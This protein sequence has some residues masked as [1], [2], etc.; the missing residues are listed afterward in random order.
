MQSLTNIDI[1][2][3]RGR[4][5]FYAWAENQC[6][7]ITDEHMH[8]VGD[9]YIFKNEPR[10]SYPECHDG[11]F[12]SLASFES[13]CGER[14]MIPMSSQS[15]CYNKVE[16]LQRESW[17][18]TGTTRVVGFLT[19]YAPHVNRLGSAEVTFN[20]LADGSNSFV[21]YHKMYT[22]FFH[23]WETAFKFSAVIYIIIFRE[24][25]FFYF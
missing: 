14:D 19:L 16:Q 21:T 5:N 17:F 24:L 7:H 3:V 23:N 4:N 10:V 8:H 9:L 12:P 1:G 25:L 18:T 13:G 11:F 6:A 2:V 22:A 20:R 15:A